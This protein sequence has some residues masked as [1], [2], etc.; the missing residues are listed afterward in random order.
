VQTLVKKR[1]SKVEINNFTNRRKRTFA[2]YGIANSFS[3]LS[4]D[5]RDWINI[6]RNEHRFDDLTWKERDLE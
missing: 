6:T 4:P 1:L 5:V 3:I 2:G